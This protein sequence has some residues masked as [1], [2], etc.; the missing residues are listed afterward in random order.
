MAKTRRVPVPDGHDIVIWQRELD[1]PTW[2]C[3]YTIAGTSYLR[4]YNP[5]YVQ[6]RAMKLDTPPEIFMNSAPKGLNLG[7]MGPSKK[8]F[9]IRPGPLH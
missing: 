6:G 3:G 4:Q 5:D 7:G 2:A 1:S 9:T 8:V